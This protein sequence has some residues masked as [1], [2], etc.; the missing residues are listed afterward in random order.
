MPGSR[1][2]ATSCQDRDSSSHGRGMVEKN[3]ALRVA[4]LGFAGAVGFASAVAVR[5]K[6]PAEALGL[7][8]PLSAPAG[9]VIGWGRPSRRPGRCRWRRW[10][11]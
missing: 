5:E 7:K 10:W 4:A 2:L 8:I 6:L 3:N 1:L 11:P 9:L